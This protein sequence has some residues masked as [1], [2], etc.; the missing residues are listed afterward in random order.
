MCGICLTEQRTSG[1][2]VIA[3]LQGI[4]YQAQ[5]VLVEIL[6]LVIEENFLDIALPHIAA[7]GIEFADVAQQLSE[8][9]IDAFAQ[10]L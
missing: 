4:L 1:R 8:Y 2:I 9:A 3:L 7:H 6:S 10:T 5:I